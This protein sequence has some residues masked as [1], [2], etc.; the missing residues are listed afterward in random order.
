MSESLVDIIGFQFER[1]HTG[2]FAW[3]LGNNGSPLSLAQRSE[4][5]SQFT[6]DLVKSDEIEQINTIREYSFGR[7]HL[8]DLVIEIDKQDGGRAALVI[9]CKTDSDV[10]LDQLKKSKE[11]YWKKTQICPEVASLAIGASQFTIA[12]KAGDFTDYGIYAI[13]L[14]QTL[15]LFANLLPVGQNHIYDDWIAALKREQA[16]T[17]QVDRTF[18]T[19]ETPWDSRLR[20]KG[21]RLGFPTFYMYYGKLRE[22]L[23]E[24]EFKSWGI[25]GGYN[26]PVLNWQG[27]WVEIEKGISLYWE[28]NWDSFRLK[29]ALE[30]D[31]SIERWRKLR[32]G[33]V[34]LCTQCSI[35]GKKTANRR[36]RWV[37]AYK[38]EF[39]FCK[40]LPREVIN[41][42]TTILTELYPQLQ[43]SS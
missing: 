36:G 26:N 30:E 14:T 35:K 16:R 29:A 4:V 43:K 3:L 40:V 5:V 25:Y 7:R 17:V 8:I 18:Q 42:V 38:W 12:H 39:D 23:E 22:L 1:I 19:M 37:S 34:K 13:D 6:P 10:N 11:E 24:S 33:I 41:T 15:N 27:A 20:D 31:G 9:E 28:F 32:P 2:I 21:Y